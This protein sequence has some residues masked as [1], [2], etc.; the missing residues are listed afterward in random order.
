MKKTADLEASV[1]NPPDSLKAALTEALEDEYRARAVYRMTLDKFGN[2][3]PFANIVEAE[4]RHVQALLPLFSKY[5][6]PIPQDNWMQRLEAPDSV[7]TACEV[8]V[9]AEIGN[10]AMYDRLLASTRDYP[11][12]QR[13]FS[14][15]QRA[16]QENHLQA[17]QQCVAGVVSSETTKSSGNLKPEGSFQ[18]GRLVALQPRMG[19]AAGN[20]RI[21]QPTGN[22]NGRGTPQ[23]KHLAVVRPRSDSASPPTAAT[24]PSAG[25]NRQGSLQAKPPLRPRA[26]P[27][28]V[29]RAVNQP[30]VRTMFWVVGLSLTMV[31]VFMGW[32]YLS[33]RRRLQEQRAV[34]L[35][36]WVQQ[37][38]GE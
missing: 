33:H 16:S 38:S 34:G 9:Q 13:V 32:R 26:T 37:L 25:S 18:A 7:Q 8:G 12:V 17:F 10:A 1:S 5:G 15:L 36:T 3:P 20:R 6:I 23:P 22:L 21:T 27:A 31:G 19:S 14:N 11:D 30:E 28:A 35:R 24:R 2:L 4:E 29:I